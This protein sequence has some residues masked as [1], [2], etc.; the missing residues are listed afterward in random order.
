MF[1]ELV[2]KRLDI[3]VDPHASDRRL[4]FAIFS[5]GEVGDVGVEEAWGILAERYPGDARFLVLNLFEEIARGLYFSE[6]DAELFFR[7]LGRSLAAR[8]EALRPALGDLCAYARLKVR[9][10]MDKAARLRFEQ[11]IAAVPLPADPE[12]TVRARLRELASTVLREC[13]QRTAHD[14]WLV[15]PSTPPVSSEP[16]ASE[17]DYKPGDSYRV[18]MRIRHARFGPGV[19]VARAEGRI[20]VAFEQ[21]HKKLICA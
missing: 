1:E 21:G 13:H 5:H 20:E 18:G 12:D 15:P 6:Y 10:K 11:M 9:R 2:E 17:V 8:T 3:E 16:G 14:E 7:K 19:V 4:L